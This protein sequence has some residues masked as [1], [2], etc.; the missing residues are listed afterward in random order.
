MLPGNESVMQL[1]IAGGTTPFLSPAHPA[2]PGVRAIAV[3]RGG[4]MGD[5]L[6]TLP[7]L[8]SL[9]DRYPQAALTLLAPPAGARLLGGRP[10]PVD[11]VLPLPVA[12][13][14]HEP[15]GEAENEFATRRFFDQARGRRFDLAVQLH[16]GGRWSNPFL[17]RLGAG[18]TVGSRAEDA[19][20]L[21]RWL[22]YQQLQHE[23]LRALEVAGLAGA[24]ATALEPSLEVLPADLAAADRVLDA[25][26]DTVVAVHPGANDPRRRWPPDRFAEVAADAV[27]AGAGVAV[28]GSAAE[29]GLVEQVAEL[30]R[31]ELPAG[32]RGAV[33]ALGGSLDESA[34]VGVLARSRLL[35]GNDSGPRHLAAA[36]GTPTVA[37]YWIGN[38]VTYG[39]L[40][41]RRHRVHAAWLTVCPECGRPATDG[42]ERCGHD[43]SLVAEVQTGAVLSDIRAMLGTP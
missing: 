9:K 2:L 7:A 3:L 14:V 11:D 34:L 13:G 35:V 32:E 40:S 43:G 15:A 33:L 8:R 10:G 37:V 30:T 18:L 29:A 19:E 23:T 1:A 12:T 27:R 22:P 41:R 25:L 20:P 24:P 21:D 42:H 16:G 17:R 31:R 36:V 4:S 26:P 5:L 39:P 38:L 28:L 6:M